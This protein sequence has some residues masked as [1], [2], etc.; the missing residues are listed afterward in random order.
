MWIYGRLSYLNCLG[1]VRDKSLQHEGRVEE[2]RAASVR[3]DQHDNP[4][5]DHDV[6]HGHLLH[7]WPVQ[8]AHLFVM[9]MQAIE[10]V[11]IGS[12]KELPFDI[13]PLVIVPLSTKP[14]PFVKLSNIT[15]CAQIASDHRRRA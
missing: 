13:L 6:L 4:D 5:H 14:S 10:V 7:C 9:A 1:L 2:P 15:T 12:L 3:E 11:L 8:C